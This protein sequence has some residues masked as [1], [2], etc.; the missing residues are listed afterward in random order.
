MTESASNLPLGA[1]SKSVLAEEAKND[2]HATPRSLLE[3]AEKMAGVMEGAL[4][5][6]VRA[7]TAFLDLSECVSTKSPDL[8]RSIRVICLANAERLS[9]K[10]PSEFANDFLNLVNETAPDLLSQAGVAGKGPF[11]KRQ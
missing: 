11:G 8:P 5:D 6:K 7:K 10:Y 1:P 4:N 2:L 3:F 9:K